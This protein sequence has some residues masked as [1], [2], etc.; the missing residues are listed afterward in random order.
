MRRREGRPGFHKDVTDTYIALW[1]KTWQCEELSY[2]GHTHVTPAFVRL[3][4]EEC[5]PGM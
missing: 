3:R 4:Q 1:G 2:M 5:K